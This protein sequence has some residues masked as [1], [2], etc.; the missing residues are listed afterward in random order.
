MSK[1]LNLRLNRGEAM[2]PGNTFACETTRDVC[3][4]H[5]KLKLSELMRRIDEYVQ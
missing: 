3:R 5:R 2:I 4:R 1:T